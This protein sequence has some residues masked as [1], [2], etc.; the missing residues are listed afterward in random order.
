[1]QTIYLLIDS[2]GIIVSAS[3]IEPT[4]IPTGLTLV[5]VSSGTPNAADALLAPSGTYAYTGGVI[6]RRPW[7]ALSSGSGTLVATLN[8]YTGT[9]MPTVAFA[10]AG[11]T[12]TA[13]AATNATTGAVTAS[14]PLL[15][16][17]S[18]QAFRVAV[19]VSAP[20]VVT[21]AANVGGQGVNP[22]K[23][24]TV[25]G[26]SPTV[27]PQNVSD[28]QAY[29]FSQF[30]NLYVAMQMTAAIQHL[31][32][33]MHR[34]AC[35]PLESGM[36]A[37]EQATFSDLTTNVFPD[38]ALTLASAQTTSAAL[39]VQAKASMLQFAGLQAQMD[40]ALTNWYS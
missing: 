14:V 1:M 19:T 33:D 37:A 35:A 38:L 29:L 16:D 5:G 21:L 7:F 28:Y 6:I 3:T 39:Y 32:Y 20:G 31:S 11:Q 15:V 10:V 30:P 25:S 4:S 18:A 27:V 24:V 8:G 2:N 34:I 17:A 9:T 36:T 23:V 22:V 12:Y 40:M 26:V 13:T